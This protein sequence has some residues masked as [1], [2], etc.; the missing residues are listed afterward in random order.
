MTDN[1][2]IADRT[3]VYL[4]APL[5]RLPGWAAAT[6]GPPATA[7]EPADL[8]TAAER[9]NAGPLEIMALVPYGATHLRLTTLPAVSC[10]E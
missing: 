1:P 2:F 5:C 10:G 3:P 7:D 6:N 9:R 4:E 8:P